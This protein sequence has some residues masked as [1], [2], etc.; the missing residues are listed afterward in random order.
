MRYAEAARI[1]PIQL[2]CGEGG[3]GRLVAGVDD[4]DCSLREG[5]QSDNLQA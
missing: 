2:E 4:W 3:T 5:S 1:T